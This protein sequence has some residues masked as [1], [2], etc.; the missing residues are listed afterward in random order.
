MALWP[1]HGVATGNVDSGNPDDEAVA[2]VTR[3]ISHTAMYGNQSRETADQNER[4]G[5]Q[6]QQM[7]W[8]RILWVTS[9]P[10]Y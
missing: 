2:I 6:K 7:R 1:I 5:T 3:N 4:K 10:R 9:L 8:A